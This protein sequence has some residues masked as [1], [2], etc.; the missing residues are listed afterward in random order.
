MILE[1]LPIDIT[2]NGQKIQITWTFGGSNPGG[3]T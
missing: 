2:D 3:D 1:A